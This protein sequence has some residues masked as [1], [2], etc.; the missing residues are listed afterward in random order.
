MQRPR[1]G[2]QGIP[3]GSQGQGLGMER[4]QGL[5]VRSLTPPPHPSPCS[6]AL[7]EEDVLDSKV[8][9]VP[10]DPPSPQSPFPTPVGSGPLLGG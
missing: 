2:R 5:R 10:P 3:E 6:M 7:G 9:P 1:C 4:P 8:G